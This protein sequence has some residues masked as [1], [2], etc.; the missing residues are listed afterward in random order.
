MSRVCLWK[1]HVTCNDVL[2][3]LQLIAYMCMC[4]LCETCNTVFLHSRERQ[5]GRPIHDMA[6]WEVALDTLAAHMVGNKG[7]QNTHK[8]HPHP[9]GNKIAII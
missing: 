3:T 7:I 6:I 9:S 5:G 2:Y 4:N 8:W 1:T